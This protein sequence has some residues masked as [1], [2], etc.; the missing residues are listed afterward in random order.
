[1]S[2]YTNPEPK[3]DWDGCWS[4][5]EQFTVTQELF[6]A[7]WGGK[8]HSGTFRCA[9][10]GHLFNVGDHAV[11]LLT[12]TG[13]ESTKGLYGNP[14]ICGDCYPGT[15]DGAIA[16]LRQAYNDYQAIKSRLWWFVER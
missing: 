7:P 11:W 10:C 8:K 4:K 14:F 5:G 9:L 12:N 13:E 6:D 3:P 15:R 2:T 1:M 16:K